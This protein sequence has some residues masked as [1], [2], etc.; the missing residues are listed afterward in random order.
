MMSC[1]I[2]PDSTSTEVLVTTALFK[3]RSQKAEEAEGQGL[4]GA[5]ADLSAPAI[6]H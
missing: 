2:I 3:I 6:S 5:W 4:H 1:V